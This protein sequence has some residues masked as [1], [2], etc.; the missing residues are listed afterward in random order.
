[1]IESYYHLTHSGGDQLPPQA[2]SFNN[3]S[4]SEQFCQVRRGGRIFS[5]MQFTPSQSVNRLQANASLHLEDDSVVWP[6][7]VYANACNYLTNNVTCPLV[8]DQSYTYELRTKL[9]DDAPLDQPFNVSF[10]V[11]DEDRDEVI[12]CFQTLVT[13]ID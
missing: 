12:L 8:A 7:D 6:I 13:A 5:R 9:P 4:S 10:T 1:M 3:C 2:I 11:R